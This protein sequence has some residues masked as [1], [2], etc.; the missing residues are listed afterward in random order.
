MANKTVF[1]NNDLDIL[2]TPYDLGILLQI[3][4]FM[5]AKIF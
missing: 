2:L 1:S 3:K 5:I 4:L